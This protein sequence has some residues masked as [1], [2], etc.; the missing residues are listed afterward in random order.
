VRLHAGISYLTPND[1]HTSRSEGIHQ[2]RR[3]GPT[4]AR[5][6]QIN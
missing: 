5:E 2:A 3:T 4:A 1:E 6:A